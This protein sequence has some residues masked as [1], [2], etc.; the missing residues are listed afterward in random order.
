MAKIRKVAA[1]AGL[2]VRLDVATKCKI[3]GEV[4]SQN[5][6]TKKEQTKYITKLA[7]ENFV[8]P[9]TIKLWV[10]KY[11][12]IWKIGSQLPEGT[13]SFAFATVPDNKIPSVNTRLAD[14]RTTLSN[15]KDSSETQYYSGLKSADVRANKTP[16]EI[17]DELILNKKAK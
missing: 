4:L 9:V 17:L 12:N 16:G 15:L 8:N 14:I 11:Q 7:T 5:F 10:G 3:V 6:L 1:I 13:M 2:H